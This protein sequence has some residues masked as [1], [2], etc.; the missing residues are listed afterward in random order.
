LGKKKKSAAL[1]DQ[2]EHVKRQNRIM[3]LR[4]WFSDQDA[5]FR[6][7]IFPPEVQK[8]WDENLDEIRRLINISDRY[9][10]IRE[11]AW[12]AWLSEKS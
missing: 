7:K 1:K 2:E 9:L 5:E 6:G 8:V 11:L 10:V 4:N 12:H 3:E